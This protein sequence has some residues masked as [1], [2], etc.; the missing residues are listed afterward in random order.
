MPE[1]LPQDFERAGRDV[2][3]FLQR[4]F[5]FRLWMITRTRGDDLI[6]LQSMDHG[7][8]VVPGMVLRWSDSLC[9]EMMQGR[10]PRIAPDAATV[11][12]YAAA[13]AARQIPIQAYIG[14]PL[15]NADG[16]LFGT[17]C[18]LDPTPQPE[19]IIKDQEMIELFGSMLSAILNSELKISEEMRRI[20]RLEVEALVDPL[21]K[22]ANR[23]AWDEFLAREEERCRR[24]GH[25]AAVFVVDLDDLK[26]VNDSAGHPAGDVLLTR[27]ADALREAARDVDVVAR[28]GG[29]E[30]GIIAVECDAEGAEKLL[31]RVRAALDRRHVRAAVGVA[32]REAAS[33]LGRAWEDADRLMYAQKR[34][35]WPLRM[36]VLPGA[37]AY[38]HPA[39]GDAAWPSNLPP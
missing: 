2:L 37:A 15:M 23:R 36:S 18:A 26:E 20:E 27:A 25:T 38:G 12:A 14:V 31:A 17:L 19:S 3:E 33:G 34:T 13:P 8:G 30:F 4:R 9:F 6:V 7:Y 35:R 29:D 16:S 39:D 1:L 32:L 10:G 24:Y 11:P 21:T 22:L 28:V 5:G